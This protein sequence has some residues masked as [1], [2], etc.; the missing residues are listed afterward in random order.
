MRSY[1]QSIDSRWGICG[2]DLAVSTDLFVSA[3]LCNIVLRASKDSFELVRFPP[4]TV[5][6]G[7]TTSGCSSGK[8][9]FYRAL[10]VKV[11]CLRLEGRMIQEA[12]SLVSRYNFLFILYLFSLLRFPM[13]HKTSVCIVLKHCNSRVS[14]WR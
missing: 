8:L 12:N 11:E 10:E 14:F 4:T 3:L 13:Q 9:R 5:V 6:L 2:V 7:R 1:I